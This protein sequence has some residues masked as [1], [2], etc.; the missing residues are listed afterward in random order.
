MSINEIKNQFQ[1][2]KS[3]LELLY[4]DSAASTL[5]PEVVIDAMNDYYQNYRSNVHRGLYDTSMKATEAYEGARHTIAS[6]INA[7]PTEIIFTNGTTHGLNMLAYSLAPRLTHRDNIVLTRMEHHANLV[8][9]QQMAKHYGFEI[10]FLELDPTSYK[11]QATSYNVIDQNTKIV[12]LVHV[13]NVLGTINPVEE[14]IKITRT[15]SPRAYTII[16]AAQ[17]IAHLPIDVKKMDCDFL[18]ASGHKMYGPTGIGFLYG[19]KVMLEEHLEPFFFG[20]D[21]VSDVTYQDAAWNE[22]PY[23]FEAGTPSI[24]S[25]IGL[26]AAVKFIR[27]IGWEEIM[28]HEQELTE[29]ALNQ[30][31]DLGV[32]IIGPPNCH[33]ERSEESLSQ[34]PNGEGSFANAQDDNKRLIRIGVLAFTIPGA[35]PHDIGEIVNR[36]GVAIRVGHHCAIPLH[37]M[38]GLTG[39]ARASLGVYN[40]KEDIDKLVEGIKEVKKIFN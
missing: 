28:R 31:T 14:I 21:M 16:D 15:K 9:W 40:T 38:L 11:L 18:V 8:P 33:S 6:F 19:K 23:K 2:F 17:S 37:K 5:T 26:G 20:G 3:N 29:Y 1:I 22:V 34:S 32:T 35:H 27:E 13:S 4:L 12:S 25:A 24:A 39:T 7:D 10:R 36:S 30:L